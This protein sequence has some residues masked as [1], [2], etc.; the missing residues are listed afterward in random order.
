MKIFKSWFT[1]RIIFIIIFY[2]RFHNQ[3][4]SH[5]PWQVVGD[6]NMTVLS[7]NWLRWWFQISF[8]DSLFHKPDLENVEFIHFRFDFNFL[9][10]LYFSNNENISQFF[11]SRA[12]LFKE[13]EGPDGDNKPWT[14]G[15]HFHWSYPGIKLGLVEEAI[16]RDLNK[17]S[18]KI[19]F[20]TCVFYNWICRE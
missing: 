13:I 12:F 17:P 5:Q 7:P 1:N 15:E 9:S 8:S 2:K 20:F 14:R 16:S 18:R 4:Y 3:S 19:A 11:F 6:V 10:T